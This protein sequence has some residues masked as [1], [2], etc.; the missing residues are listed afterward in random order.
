MQWIVMGV[1][2]LGVLGK[3]PGISDIALN[4][5]GVILLLWV[6]I[7]FVLNEWIRRII[8]QENS[9]SKTNERNSNNPGRKLP[10]NRSNKNIVSDNIENTKVRNAE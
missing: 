3:H 1:V 2:S 8:R 4:T 10:K 9:Q 7:P 6:F 5:F